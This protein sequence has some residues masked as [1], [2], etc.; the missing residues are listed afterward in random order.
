[1]ERG[2]ELAGIRLDSGDLAYLSIEARKMLDAAGFAN[3]R[4]A[5]SNDLDEHIITSL[6]LQGARVDVW[7]VGTRLVTAFDQPAL[8]G[9]YKLTAIRKEGADWEYK[10]KLSEQLIKISNPGILQVRRFVDGGRA[11]GDMI[12]SEDGQTP[13]RTIVDPL[14]RTRRK[15]FDGAAAAEDL[16]VPIF[17]GGTRVYDPPP[18]DAVR[19]RREQQLA[20][21]HGGIKRLVHPHRYPVGLERQLFEL[22]TRLVLEARGSQNRSG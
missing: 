10:I 3:A 18:L 12:F 21:F 15:D 8:G 14:D 19:A 4:I 7:G 17:R 5:A 11:I 9:V 13:T 2:H 22:K 1:R 16:L 20:L 6:K